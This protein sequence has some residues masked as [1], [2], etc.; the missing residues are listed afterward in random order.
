MPPPPRMVTLPPIR[1][2]PGLAQPGR[3]PDVRAETA[4]AGE[5]QRQRQLGD[6][7]GEDPL[8]A[9][10][11]A[12]VLHEVH[13]R[14][15]AG[16]RQL[17]PA[18]SARWRRARPRARRRREAA[19]TSAPRLPRPARHG[20]RRRRLRP[21]A[22]AGRLRDRDRLRFE[23]ARRCVSDFDEACL[24]GGMHRE[25]S[26]LHEFALQLVRRS[27]PRLRGTRSTSRRALR[28]ARFV[29]AVGAAPPRTR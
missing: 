22:S 9:C 27:R 29:R 2:R 28:P 15:D 18:R 25:V 8:A 10:P 20:H 12:V 14:L 4:H 5:R 16:V 17:H 13:E 3:R 26:P 7:L 23:V 19:S 24:L 21:A 11:H 6:G 1:L